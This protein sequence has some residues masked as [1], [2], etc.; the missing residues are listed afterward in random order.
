[1]M[2]KRKNHEYF[3]KYN[4]KGF[5]AI[6]FEWN[7][8]RNPMDEVILLVVY[9]N[10]DKKVIIYSWYRSVD[11]IFNLIPIFLIQMNWV[12]NLIKILEVSFSV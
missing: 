3:M 9:I 6:Q 7:K 12:E 4:V 10:N 8:K 11:E 1:M 2:S 5:K